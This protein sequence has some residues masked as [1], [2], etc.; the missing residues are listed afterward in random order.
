MAKLRLQLKKENPALIKK[1]NELIGKIPVEVENIRADLI[2]E[3]TLAE[4]KELEIRA[5]KVIYQLQDFFEI[6]G[7]PAE[8]IEIDG[9]L[10]NFKYLGAAMNSGTCLL[11]TSPSPRDRQKSRMPSSA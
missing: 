1:D 6:K 3:M 4:I 9:D 11:Y 2:K 10:S 7:K 8:E 5:G